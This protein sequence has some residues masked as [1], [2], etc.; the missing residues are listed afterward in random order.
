VLYA[1]SRKLDEPDG[2]PGEAVRRD[3]EAAAI[4]RGR[5][6]GLYGRR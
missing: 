1:L 4:A 6:V 3:A 5:L 2:A